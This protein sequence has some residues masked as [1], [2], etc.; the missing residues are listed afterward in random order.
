MSEMLG[1]NTFLVLVW[2]LK[3][4]KGSTRIK[5]KNYRNAVEGSANTL[6]FTQL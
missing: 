4:V 1:K 2:N 3:T 6:C 5:D